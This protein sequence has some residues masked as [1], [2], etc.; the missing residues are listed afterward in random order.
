MLKQSGNP[1]SSGSKSEPRQ[2]GTPVHRE[3]VFSLLS[4]VSCL[5][6]SVLPAHPA[7]LAC[8]YTCRD[9]S[10]NPPVLCKTKPISK[11]AI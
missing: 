10:T 7:Q 9:S 1:N 3:S 8:L 4:P 5:L 11:W 6:S 2:T